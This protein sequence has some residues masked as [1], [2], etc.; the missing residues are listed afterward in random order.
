MAE[1][2]QA[3]QT[4]ETSSKRGRITISVL[5]FIVPQLRREINGPLLTDA[6]KKEKQ[7]APPSLISS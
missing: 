7:G 2:K 3:R 5:Y 1:A 6:I 4:I